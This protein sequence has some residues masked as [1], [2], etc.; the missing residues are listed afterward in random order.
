M[1]HP[2]T[3]DPPPDRRLVTLPPVVTLSAQQQRGVHCVFCGTALHT[4]AVRDLGP[5][6]TEAHGS[7]VQWFPRSCPSC[8]KVEAGSW[9]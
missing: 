9:E 3:P 6:L 2:S 7:V 4:G 5:Q 1:R 8:P